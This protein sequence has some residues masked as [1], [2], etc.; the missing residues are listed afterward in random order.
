MTR[1]EFGLWIFAAAAAYAICAAGLYAED[2]L[3]WLR[4]MIA[5]IVSCRGG[6]SLR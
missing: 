4:R 1:L 2:M 5:V 3:R 6:V